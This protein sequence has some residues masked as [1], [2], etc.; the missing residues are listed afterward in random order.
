MVALGSSYSLILCGFLLTLCMPFAQNNALKR[1]KPWSPEQRETLQWLLMGTVLS[2]PTC[3]WLHVPTSSLAS[4][5]PGRWAVSSWKK[6]NQ[7]KATLAE[8]DHPV[9]ELD[10]KGD[11]TVELEKRGQTSSSGGSSPRGQQAL[12]KNLTFTEQPGNTA[13]K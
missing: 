5:V 1:H 12:R 3:S 9:P 8:S 11:V 13:F 4:L 6:L 2:T 10:G 7:Q